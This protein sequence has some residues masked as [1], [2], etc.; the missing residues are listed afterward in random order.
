[1]LMKT[2]SEAALLVFLGMWQNFNIRKCTEVE[3]LHRS[4]FSESPVSMAAS[5]QAAAVTNLKFL[6]PG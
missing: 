3:A 5:N 1:M 4:G 6:H 2:L